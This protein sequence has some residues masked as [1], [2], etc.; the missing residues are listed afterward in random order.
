[1]TT[2][3]RFFSSEQEARVVQA[4]A[5]AENNTSGEIKLHIQHNMRFDDPVEEAKYCFKRLKLYE[6]KDRNAILFF[7]NPT[8]HKLAVF[9]DQGINAVVPEHYWEEMIAQMIALFKQ[10]KMVEAFEY[11][12][13]HC[14]EKLKAHF[15]HQGDADVNEISDEISEHED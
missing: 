3:P 2:K 15:P 1:M 6:T 12:F 10:G 9:A 7:V 13:E 4:I 11:G 5:R 14:G 8:E